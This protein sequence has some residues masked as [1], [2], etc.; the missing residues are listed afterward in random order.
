MFL[1]V[2]HSREYQ[3]EI[4]YTDSLVVRV[5]CFHNA[6]IMSTSS[7]KTRNVATDPHL[8]AT[9]EKAISLS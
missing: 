2:L 6:Y 9:Q 5:A 8:K 4:G 3:I 1:F 7:H